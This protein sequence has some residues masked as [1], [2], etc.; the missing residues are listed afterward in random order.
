[1]KTLVRAASISSFWHS[2]VYLS[3]RKP[4]NLRAIAPD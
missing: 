3:E 1:V 4:P 2:N